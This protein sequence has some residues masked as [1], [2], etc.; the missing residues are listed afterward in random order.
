MKTLNVFVTGICRYLIFFLIAAV[1]FAVWNGNMTAIEIKDIIVQVVCLV[2]MAVSSVRLLMNNKITIPLNPILLP[3]VLYGL[4]MFC[5]F[6]STARNSINYSVFIPQ[7]YGVITFFLFIFHFTRDDFRKVLPVCVFIAGIASLYGPIQYFNADPVNWIHKAERFKVISFFGHKNYFAIYLLLMIPFGVY[8]SFF[9]DKKPVLYTAILSTMA[10]VVALILS[11]SRGAVICFF[12]SAF[13]SSLFFILCE[14]KNERFS[15]KSLGIALA[16]PAI[17]LVTFMILPQSMKDDFSRLKNGFSGRVSFYYAAAEIIAKYPYFGV[18]PGNFVI[19]YPLN[20]KHKTLTQDPNTVLN[21]VHNDFLEIWVEYGI[22]ALLVY[23]GL[24]LFL[25]YR[26]LKQALGADTLNQRLL[27]LSLFCSVAGYLGYSTFTVATRYMSST[28]F[29]WITF[30]LIYLQL[31][32]SVKTKTVTV[33]N[34]AA[35]NAGLRVIGVVLIILVFGGL[36][37]TAFADYLSDV[38]VHRASIRIIKSDFNGALELLEKAAAL[39][40]KQVEAWYQRGYVHF[41]MNLF[42]RAIADYDQARKLAPNYVN[43]AFNTA[44]CY[45]R[46]NDW[47]N[48]IKYAAISHEHFPDYTPN[49]VMLAFCYYYLRQPQ[50]ALMYC[51]KALK[52]DPGNRKIMDLRKELMALLQRS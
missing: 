48:A 4:L 18:G 14:K 49:S 19:Y 2:V 22:F 7:I 51:N 26:L 8:C 24:V 47:V 25:G 15:E 30:G 28:F 12:I 21:H 34:R 42:D 16:V 45:Y 27:S 17:A 29:L 40:E 38:Y 9:S 5:G 37:K 11:N 31:Q 10:M 35:H 6:L 23:L 39:R 3:A 20:E 1:V 36:G 33:R 46:K 44:S 32:G 43:I 50:T 13:I 41:N 52:I